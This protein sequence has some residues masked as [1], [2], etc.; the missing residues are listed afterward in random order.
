MPVRTPARSSRKTMAAVVIAALAGV[1]IVTSL[2]SAHNVAFNN[3]V[4]VDRAYDYGA[5]QG[6]YKGRVLTNRAPCK[7]N[8]EVQI[9]RIANPS[10]VR[11]TTT[12]TNNVGQWKVT[13]ARL[14]P[15]S[16][17]YALIE[18]KVLPSPPGHNHTCR[19]D[20]SGIRAYPY[21]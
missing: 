5:N 4:V 17:L 12:R 13:A 21:P 1:V 16:K 8:R 2:A 20:R 18:T 7:Q 9:W 14:A 15:G 3:N 6:L 10:D 11:I 19:L